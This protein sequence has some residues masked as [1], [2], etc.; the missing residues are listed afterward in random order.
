MNWGQRV[1]VTRFPSECKDVRHFNTELVSW[2]ARTGPGATLGESHDSIVTT[3]PIGGEVCMLRGGTT[4][5]GVTIYLERAARGDAPFSVAPSTKDVVHRVTIGE[6]L[7]RIRGLYLYTSE[8]YSK[9]RVIAAADGTAFGWTDVCF[10]LL[11]AVAFLHSRGHQRLRIVPERGGLNG[12]RWQFV[13]VLAENITSPDGLPRWDSAVFSRSDADGYRVGDIEVGPSTPVS[14]L[15]RVLLSGATDLGVGIDWAYAG[16]YAELLGEARRLR[17]LPVCRSRF[18]FPYESSWELWAGSRIAFPPPPPPV[19]GTRIG[20]RD[21][22][23]GG[24][25]EEEWVAPF[26]TGRIPI[27]FD[28]TKVREFSGLVAGFNGVG[29]AFVGLWAMI[30]TKV[31]Y[32]VDGRWLPYVDSATV[33]HSTRVPVSY[34]FIK[35]FD[36]LTAAKRRP[37]WSLA[38]SM[39]V[40]SSPLTEIEGD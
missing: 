8:E 16:W 10:K 20:F 24:P 28:P 35:S 15:A 26:P 19:S 21:V 3:V 40:F 34:R 38:Q 6:T 11:D 2:L 22:F 7:E 18:D 32:R 12:S 23:P 25:R 33:A 37:L 39:R 31:Y 30:G 17:Q 9:P 14:S 4:R 5:E 13:V 1:S 36:I 27:D 29:G